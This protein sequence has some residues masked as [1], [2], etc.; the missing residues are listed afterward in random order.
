MTH[1]ERILAAI[2]GRVPD[3]LPFAPRLE[4]WYRARLRNN[5][6]PEEVRGLTLDEISEHRPS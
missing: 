2:E 6:M 1:R 3:R 4:F 5:T